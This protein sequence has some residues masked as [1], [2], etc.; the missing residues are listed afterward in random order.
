MCAIKCRQRQ[1]L[2]LT[3]FRSVFC[4]CVCVASMINHRI[5][6]I[7]DRC[8]VVYVF[9]RWIFGVCSTLNAYVCQSVDYLLALNHQILVKTNLFGMCQLVI[10]MFGNSKAICPNKSE[11]RN[12][13]EKVCSLQLKLQF[14]NQFSV[15]R[16]WKMGNAIGGAL[17][18]IS[19]CSAIVEYL[20][21][22]NQQR[23]HIF[24][25]YCIF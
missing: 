2:S 18:F 24:I 16:K 17:F 6:G 4:L 23:M 3:D 25:A 1:R 11:K 22:V 8:R 21:C 15:D 9:V 12:V 10:E 20:C 7:Y 14:H 19:F 13:N 5:G